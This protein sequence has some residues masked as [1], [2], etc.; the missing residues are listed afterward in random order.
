[1][2]TPID[3]RIKCLPAQEPIT[4]IR[5]AP[6]YSQSTASECWVVTGQNTQGTLVSVEAVR[7]YPA[8]CIA[9]PEHPQAA[10]LGLG[11]VLLGV[12]ARRTLAFRTR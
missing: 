7:P 6:G 5:L 12:Y 10:G 4:T 1:V 2:P 11:L 9:L 3:I 8:D